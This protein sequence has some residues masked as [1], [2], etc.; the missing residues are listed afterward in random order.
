[1]GLIVPIGEAVLEE[2]CRQAKGWQERWPSDP[3]ALCVNL[4]AR[5]FKE[6]GLAHS[7]ARVLKETGL[8]P[9]NL[10]LEVTESTAMGDALTTAAV[11]EDILQFG[12]RMVLDD[13]GTGHSSLSYLERFP[14]DYVKIDP[15]FVGRL[16]KQPSAEMLVSGIIDLVHALGLEVIAE[17]VETGEQL[18]LLRAA[19]CDL[20]QGYLFSKP[21]RGEEILKALSTARQQNVLSSN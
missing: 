14:V 12:V 10:L 1:T 20:A 7:V 16:G 17:G 15:S 6:P 5:Q 13:F 19:G 9:S 8:E 4:S 3:P 2:A 18:Q 11:L 21:I